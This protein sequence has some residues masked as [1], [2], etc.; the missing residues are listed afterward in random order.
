M[1]ISVPENHIYKQEWDQASFFAYP[2]ISVYET[3][4]KNLNTDQI[5]NFANTHVF[6]L[7]SWHWLGRQILHLQSFSLSLHLLCLYDSTVNFT[8]NSQEFIPK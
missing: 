5:H 6:Q 4:Q 3:K 7:K 8:F 2:A 1:A